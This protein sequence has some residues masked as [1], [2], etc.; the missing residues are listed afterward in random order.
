MSQAEPQP[1]QAEHARDL[2]R[3]EEASSSAKR[4]YRSWELGALD[5]AVDVE[6]IPMT[7]VSSPMVWLAFSP[8]YA[9]R[10]PC[11]ATLMLGMISPEVTSVP[12]CTTSDA[13]RSSRRSPARGT[14]RAKAP[15]WSPIS[16]ASPSARDFIQVGEPTA[17][18]HLVC[19]GQAA[20][21]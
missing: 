12:P 13:E 11:A 7:R 9:M 17:A 6:R 16:L 5:L 10:G 14:S 15:F 4:Q 21:D 18:R 8:T 3:V 1:P 20:R 19:S 2:V